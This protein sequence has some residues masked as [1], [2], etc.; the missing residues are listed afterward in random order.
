[1]NKSLIDIIYNLIPKRERNSVSI[2]ILI[3]IF[4]YFINLLSLGLLIPFFSSIIDPTI[5]LKMD[6]VI[7]ILKI[8]DMDNIKTNIIILYYGLFLIF[9]L[10]SSS[11]LLFLN[12]RLKVKLVKNIANSISENYVKK[13]I[14][15]DYLFFLNFKKN[16]V[17]SKIL[18][19]TESVVNQ[20]FTSFFELII[21]LFIV[22]T[23]VLGL[24]YFKPDIA[25]FASLIIGVS[26]FTIYTM[27]KNKLKTLGENMVKGNLGRSESI[28]EI[29]QNFVSIRV[30]DLKK[31]TTERF[32]K[33]TDI[34]FSN[35]SKTEVVKKYPKIFL[36]FI[37]FCIVIVILIYLVMNPDNSDE[38]NI[39]LISTFAIA[40][41][42]LMPSIQMVFFSISTIRN[43]YPKLIGI[44]NDI[45]ILKKN[46]SKIDKLVDK[47]INKYLEEK[48]NNLINFKFI[49]AEKISLKFNNKYLFKNLSFK[50]YKNSRTCIMGDSGSG[51]TSLL[52]IILGLIKPTS[53]F[54]KIDNLDIF[55]FSD[56]LRSKI[57]SYSPQLTNLF[58]ESLEENIIL[59]NK[60]NNNNLKSTV[61]NASLGY[62]FKNRRNST[63]INNKLSGG[64]LKRVLIA[65]A[66]YNSG[67]I[68]IFDEP[69]AYL[70]RN[71]SKK[72]ISTLKNLKNQTLI[73]TTHDSKLKQIATQKIILN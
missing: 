29:I 38:E 32:V 27:I 54:I 61:R 21:R 14:N 24:I 3:S 53:G 13:L 63:F 34:Y 25:L 15:S 66:L 37:F 56:V 45:N 69:T 10:F 59:N 5:F 51:K 1:M 9:L 52:L 62:L 73:F 18:I 71:N 49:K 50:I 72:I 43:N 40:S 47:K 11:V 7:S 67:S 60:K 48:K 17:F 33:F 41:Y 46:A 30:F 44:N 55:K 2:F 39:V 16:K 26:F 31:K 36:E 22:L 70:D 64:E 12:E 58:N 42:R 19:E 28:N 20:L 8:L 65:R 6:L 35:F 68:K 4:F 23:I 57:F